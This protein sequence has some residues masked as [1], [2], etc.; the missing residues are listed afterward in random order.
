MMFCTEIKIQTKDG[1][2]QIHEGPIITAL[3][4]KE[5][6]I[7]ALEMNKDLKVTTEY[8]DSIKNY[9]EDGMGF[10]KF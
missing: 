10:F 4:L 2:I 7:K 1:E 5:A 9:G 6:K 3:N 8:I